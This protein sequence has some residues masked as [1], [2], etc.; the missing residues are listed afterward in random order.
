MQI[1][2][3]PSL[4]KRYGRTLG[5]NLLGPQKVCSYDCVYCSLGPT[6][7]TMNAIRKDYAFPSL[8]DLRLKFKEYIRA[9]VPI[10]HIVVSGNGEPTLYPEFDQAMQAVRELRDAHLPKTRIV[11]LTNGA[12][13]DSKKTVTGLNLADERVIKIDAG[14]D[15]LFHRVNAPL[16]RL[17]LSKFLS[18]FGKLKGYAVQ[19][20]FVKGDIDNTAADAIDDWIEILG[21]L[22]PTAVQ[23]CTLDKPAPLYPG[24]HAADEDTLYSIAFRL[25]KRTGLE[26]NVFGGQSVKTA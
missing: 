9:S 24:L 26:T 19:A 3:G 10:D 15:P 6:Q 21:M 25:K 11:V 12:H 7:M 13:L 20:M 4:S 14:N 18:N 17:N 2:Y 22:K 5:I 16:V 1:V 23:I 8:D